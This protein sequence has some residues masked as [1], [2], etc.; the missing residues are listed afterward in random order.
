[1]DTLR[2]NFGS[3]D[4]DADQDGYDDGDETDRELPPAAIGTDERR[5]QVRAYNHWASLLDERNFPSIEDLE[6]GELPDFGPY[7]VLLDFTAGIDDPAIQ[8]LGAE[9][10]SECGT[11]TEIAQ[12]SDV[13]SRSLL[14][15]IT[16]HYMQ[17]LANQAPIGFEA[18]FVNQ[19]EAT[20]LY[21]GIL[22]PYS[23]DG[24][25][26][27]FIYG[28]I[29]WKEM[30]DQ[31][32]TDELLLEIDQAL[33]LDDSA[34]EARSPDP[35]TDWADGPVSGES[36]DDNEQFPA[37]AFGDTAESGG[38][39]N[40]FDE[41]EAEEFG[42]DDGDV[43]NDQDDIEDETF[44]DDAVVERL[45]SLIQPRTGV[46]AGL[47]LSGADEGDWDQDDIE[48]EG[49]E[50]SPLMQ[51]P[52]PAMPVAME[53]ELVPEQQVESEFVVDPNAG[54]HDCLAEARELAQVART[55]EDRTRSALYAAVGRAYDVSVAAQDAPEDFEELVAENGLT[56]QNRAPMTP[57]VKLV[58]GA[59][60]DKTR[61]T[62]YASV[63]S[64][65]QRMGIER[66]ALSE[67]LANAD[68]GLKGV[69]QAERRI[70]KEE[71]GKEVAPLD[72]PKPSLAKKLR[73]ID[74]QSLDSIDPQGAEF[75]VVMIRRLTTGEIV[76]LGEVSDDIPLV[77]KVA[78][79]L[80]K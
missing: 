45:S 3:T 32:T 78:R 66:G 43:W 50:A 72:A 56:I 51:K 58:F 69:V 77:E 13:P 4:Y 6:P 80:L 64:H 19:R 36:A 11:E 76:V 26:I 16:D 27:D 44:S 54:L 33:E 42:E 74:G 63:L 49:N 30:A 67:F 71:S 5:M 39:E 17:I 57:V 23:S 31:V 14:S 9:L 21:R 7:S 22:L 62:E 68:G 24:E 52:A 2:G 1:M 12:L 48:I 47:D 29:N 46:T 61:L 40:A 75:G 53:E 28:V 79:K 10:A 55:S 70:R 18:E 60:Y 8:Y 73:K 38:L 59:D 37:P 41:D 35:V 65:A 25:T 34:E 15:R 20:I